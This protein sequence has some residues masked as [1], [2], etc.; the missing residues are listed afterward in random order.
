MKGIMLKLSELSTKNSTHSLLFSGRVVG[1][2]G[3]VV[4][5]RIPGCAVGDLCQITHRCGSPVKARVISFYEDIVTLA[6]FDS[7]RG[8]VPGAIIES[9]NKGST[10]DFSDTLIGR[11]LDS[12]GNVLGTPLDS[13]T[14]KSL[15]TLDLH[16][17]PPAA[18]ERRE[19]N[20]LLATGIKAIDGFC[21]LGYGQRMGLFAGPGLGKSTLLAM[22][23]RNACVDLA[24]IALVGERGREVNEFIKEALGESGMKKSILV[25][26]TSDES[27]ARRSLAAVTATR[28]AEYFRDQGKNVLLLVDSLTR[29]ARAIRDLALSAGEMPV[30]QGYPSSVY[31]ELPILLERAGPSS[32]GTITSV[33]TVLTTGGQI[34]NDDP[35]GEEVMSLLDGHL[36][37]SQKVK[38]QGIRPSI[39]LGTSVSRLSRQLKNEKD[40]MLSEGVL[41]IINRLE[42]DKDILLF[43]GEPD[44]ELAAAFSCQTMIA[45]LLNQ[46]PHECVKLSETEKLIST[47]YSRY[48]EAL[49]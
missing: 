43:G 24:V 27:A 9:L 29:V 48:C 30:R 13:E 15:V 16:N 11:V 38:N 39:D 42:R 12:T 46:R 44:R 26:S 40:L 3:S 14:F 35:L 5:A 32:K 19:I 1:I 25:V 34:E 45:D 28:I 20:S 31:A 18:L 7:V 21:P 17:P 47:L 37:L 23:A 8:I 36:V 2:K 4:L 22:I 49:T 10:I 33:Y 41:K 6:P